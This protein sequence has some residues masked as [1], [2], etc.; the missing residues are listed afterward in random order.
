LIA[1]TTAV[2]TPLYAVILIWTLDFRI[3][4][5]DIALGFIAASVSGWAGLMSLRGAHSAAWSGW[6]KWVSAV[7]AAAWSVLLLALGLLDRN[8]A[9][10]AVP[11]V[12]VGLTLGASALTGVSRRFLYDRKFPTI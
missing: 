11:L 7:I 3:I 10:V 12:A 5:L 4:A 8:R 1:G 2:I 9:V 6:S